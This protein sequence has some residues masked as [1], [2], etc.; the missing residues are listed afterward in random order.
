VPLRSPASIS[1][2][3]DRRR[4]QVE[5]QVGRQDRMLQHFVESAA[6]HIVPRGGVLKDFGVAGMAAGRT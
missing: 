6:P 4:V 3:V 5:A 2:L 1:R